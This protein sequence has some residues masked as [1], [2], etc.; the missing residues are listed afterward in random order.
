M[1]AWVIYESM[2][3]NT[4]TIATAIAD[5][6]ATA[7]PVEVF[8][9]G[10]A[11]TSIGAEVELLVIGGPTHVFGLSRPTTRRDAAAALDG[12]AVSS[13]IGVREWVEAART[14]RTGV[15]AAAFDTHIDKAVPGSA[16]AAL[17]KRLRRL[18]LSLLVAP[19]SFH[20]S[21]KQGP[22]VAGEPQR[23]HDWGVQLA[24]AHAE[25]RQQAG[26]R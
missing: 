11:P 2:Y 9:V 25:A 7:M 26:T 17:G 5:G 22:L 24:A 19:R 21:D 12:G 16:S 8:E 3:G 4:R 14:H 6:L 1:V 10:D 15:F 18:G 23:A 20:V 13:G